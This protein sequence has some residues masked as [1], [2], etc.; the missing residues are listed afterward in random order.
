MCEISGDCACRVAAVNTYIELRGRG[1]S[2]ANA[3]D[4]AM[5]VLWFHNPD[6][7]MSETRLQL[8][9]WLD[10]NGVSAEPA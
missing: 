3:F 7:S 6:A 1:V 10:A 4:T 5:R 9:E 2:D 8:A